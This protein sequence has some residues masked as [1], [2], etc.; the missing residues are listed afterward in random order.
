MSFATLEEAWG[1]STFGVEE[2]K[3]E[4]K[5]P[6]VQAAILDRTEAS[7]R[8]FQF[9]TSYLREV[10]LKHGVAGILSLLDA[11]VVEELRWAMLATVDFLNGQTLMFAFMCIC[12]VWLL[13]DAMK[14]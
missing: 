14:K 11:Q 4:H 8:S 3:P 12:A 2:I 13:I 6:Q 1:V 7:Q 9:V 10:Y 5:D